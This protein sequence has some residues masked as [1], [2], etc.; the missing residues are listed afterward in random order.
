MAGELFDRKAVLRVGEEGGTGLEIDEQFR[1][2]FDIEKTIDSASNK[3][4]FHVYNL[5]ADSRDRIREEN[6]IVE[7]EAAKRPSGLRVKSG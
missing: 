7:F 5:S 1:I 4:T 2:A 6:Q 3:A